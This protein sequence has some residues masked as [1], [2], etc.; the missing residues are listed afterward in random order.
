ME[1]PSTHVDYD[2]LERLSQGDERAF[3][4][5]FDAYRKKLYFFILQIV[6]NESI[7]ED[8]VQDVFVRIWSG[9]EKMS[10]VGK[11]DSYLFIAARNRALDVIRNSNV[12]RS[13]RSEWVKRS[14][15]QTGSA[16]EA[17]DFRR[18]KKLIDEA[19]AQLPTQQARVFR[20]SKEHMLK[21]H[22]VARELGVSENTV[23]NH[24]S[25]A[26]KSIKRYL[27]EHGG[28]T[29]LLLLLWYIL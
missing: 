23:R 3:R 24:L 19:V 28:E 10:S 11:F 16:E 2:I 4:A 18:S 8:L 15:V 21:R 29:A 7:A 5:V 22:E 25:E 12:E 14:S 20:L 9:R 1:Y 6:D 27:E 13:M 26:I 17:F